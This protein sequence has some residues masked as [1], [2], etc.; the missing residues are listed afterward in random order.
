MCL[1]MPDSTETSGLNMS[2]RQTKF[3]IPLR[4]L[5]LPQVGD[6]LLHL[7]IAKKILENT[8]HPNLAPH[9]RSHQIGRLCDPFPLQR[10]L[11][12]W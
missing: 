11:C 5:Y 9:L 2:L 12:L 8:C 1:K 6:V 10:R 4:D 3:S 7:K